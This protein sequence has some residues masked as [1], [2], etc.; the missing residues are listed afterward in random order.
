MCY[1]QHHQGV[2][3]STEASDNVKLVAFSYPLLQ[4]LFQT[5]HQLRDY[6]ALLEQRKI[7]K[8]LQTNVL[9]VNT[10]HSFVHVGVMFPSLLIGART[11]KQP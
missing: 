10:H 1:L 4:F 9:D 3:D 6:G 7:K 11:D 8:Y 2:K 5:R